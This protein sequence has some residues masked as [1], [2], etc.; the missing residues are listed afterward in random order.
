MLQAAHCCRS[1]AQFLIQ[2][3]ALQQAS[4][5]GLTSLLPLQEADTSWEFDIFSLAESSA[6]R[7]L[8]TLGFFLITVRTQSSTKWKHMLLG[9]CHAFVRGIKDPCS[10]CTWAQASLAHPEH[11]FPACKSLNFCPWP[12]RMIFSGECTLLTPQWRW[13]SLSVAF[14]CMM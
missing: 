13:V 4:Y 9:I 12:Q 11:G 1:C 8:S 2:V 14:F 7:P 3:P 6:N 5:Q 10:T